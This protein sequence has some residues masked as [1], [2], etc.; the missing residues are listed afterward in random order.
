MK[1]VLYDLPCIRLDE[2]IARSEEIELSRSQI[3]KLIIEGMVT[4]NEK[5]VTKVATRLEIR[6]VVTIETKEV[7]YDHLNDIDIDILFEDDDLLVVNK[8]KNLV[9]HPSYIGDPRITLVDILKKQGIAL[10]S[11]ENRPG[12]VHRIDKD[13]TGCLI[14]A[15]TVRAL[16]ALS[17]MIADKK[18]KR[19]YYAFVEGEVTSETG[20][21]RGK[22]GTD[23]LNPNKK[24]VTTD[25]KEAITHFKRLEV[26]NGFSLLDC[27]LETGRTHQIRVHLA[28]ISHPI[29]G[30]PLYNNKNYEGISSQLLHAYR[31][32]F[33]HPFTMKNVNLY[34]PIPEAFYDFSGKY[35]FSEFYVT[36]IQ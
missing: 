30:D 1:L 31:I 36:V 33:I 10:A 14:I 16:T 21:I 3:K 2:A 25:G 19:K 18:V 28:A 8:G 17:K 26:N 29:V 24:T 13:T 35:K 12:I 32:E 15:K 9:V 6:D 4:V 11:N 7:I 27:E 20:T 34:A 5:V 23:K 22:I